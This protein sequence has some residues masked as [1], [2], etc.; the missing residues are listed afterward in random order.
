MVGRASL[1]V[2]IGF[3]LIFGIAG[4]YWNRESTNAM[5]NYI[6]YYGQSN[7][8]NIASA[9]ANIGCDSLF[10][11]VN[12]ASLS[13]SGQFAGGDY[14]VTTAPV[15][16][17]SSELLLQ[18]V[19]SYSDYSGSYGD[20]VQVL[21]TKRQY[22]QWEFFSNSENGV[23]WKTGDT[24]SGPM[25]TNDSL[26]VSGT[27]VFKGQVSARSGI[28]K[29][30]PATPKFLA[31]FQSGVSYNM[32]SVTPTASAASRQFTNSNTNTSST[33]DVYMAF[34]YNTTTG[35]ED[36]SFHTVTYV[37]SGRSGTTTRVPA[38]G[39]S[40]LALS[41]FAPNG[42]VAISNG[43]AHVQGV[44]GGQLTVVDQ[45]GAIGSANSG[46]IF[47]D[48]NV[49]YQNDP[50]TN[51]GSTDML[52][53]VAQN[54]VTLTVGQ[55]NTYIDAAIYAQNGSFSYSGWSS[56]NL[57]GSAY[58]HLLG[59]IANL[60]R[61]PVGTFNSSTGMM[62]TGYN[63]SYTYDSRFAS[64]APPSFPYTGTFAIVTWRETPPEM[65]N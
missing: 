26:Y 58:I 22:S 53:L 21:L 29:S 60:T 18:S 8:Y 57:G 46:N 20:T 30:L 52:G 49:T 50:R 40:V 11:D 44:L 2:I 48:N 43:D 45:Q 54:N 47:I 4:Q 10:N 56:T 59:S 15:A 64:T 62:A 37:P 17:H 51:P 55:A 36:V 7:V 23:Y 28:S 65:P 27:P 24:V 41:S 5:E 39:D 19:S 14:T 25:A 9:G 38:S 32:S 31:G 63:K 13:L 35:V 12:L 34:S 3:A 6:Q 61:G 1:I 42:V 33:Y 16:G